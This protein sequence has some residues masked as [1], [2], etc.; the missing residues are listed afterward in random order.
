M[1]FDDYSAHLPHHVHY[2][3]FA[4]GYILINICGE[5]TGDVQINDIHNHSAVKRNYR[6]LETELMLKQLQEMRD[7]E[8]DK[9]VSEPPKKKAKKIPS[10]SRDED[11]SMFVEV[12]ENTSVDNELAFTQN[13]DYLASIMLMDLVGDEIKVFRE[14]LLKSTPPAN[15]SALQ[16]SMIPPEGGRRKGSIK[17][18][19]AELLDCEGDELDE[20]EISEDD[21]S[22]SDIDDVGEPEQGNEQEVMPLEEG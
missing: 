3:L 17:D 13:M 5:I 10:P 21:K 6:T 20:D 14:A 8:A 2:A 9:D 4:K 16:K 22:D 11:M 1:T 18:D 19:G 12:W 15:W 7:K